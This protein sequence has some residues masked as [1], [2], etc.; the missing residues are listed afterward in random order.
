MPI[1]LFSRIDNTVKFCG[2]YFHGIIT[3]RFFWK[4]FKISRFTLLVELPTAL[5]SYFYTFPGEVHNP[6]KHTFF[7]GFY[8]KLC[9]K[10]GHGV[11]AAL[12]YRFDFV[13]TSKQRRFN[14]MF[15]V[16]SIRKIHNE[17]LP[18][19]TS[20]T[21]PYGNQIQNCDCVVFVRQ[22]FLRW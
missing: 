13:T 16:G 19:L 17:I 22:M 11:T 12:F 3:N 7:S 21:A 6:L 1:T 8:F 14:G 10:P 20:Y 9:M 15:P 5:Y 4:S 18:N 2:N